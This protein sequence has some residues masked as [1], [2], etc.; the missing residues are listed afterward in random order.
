M[1]RKLFILLFSFALGIGL[2]IGDAL[3]ILA[4]EST[5]EEFTLEEITVTAQKRAENQQ[6]VGIPMAV[7]SGDALKELGRNDIDQILSQVSSAFI[8]RTSEGL[9]V[10]LR[11]VG[12]DTPAGYGDGAMNAPGTVSVN[13]NGVYTSKRPTGTG[14]Y[15]IERV[16]VLF[17]PQ[18]TMYA[19]NAP[20]GIVNVETA[21]PKLE[22]YE[23]GGTLEYA[24]Y[25]LLHTEGVINA[26]ISKSLAFRAAFN[27]TVRDG[28]VSNGGDDEDSKSARLRALWKPNDKFSFLITGEYQISSDRGMSGVPAFISQDDVKDPWYNPT[29]LT[30]SPTK[31]PQTKINGQIDY[32]F[33][34]ASMTIIPSKMNEDYDRTSSGLDR[35]GQPTTGST[36]G[37]GYEKGLETRFSSPGDSSIKWIVAVNMFKG[38]NYRSG[39]TD[40]ASGAHYQTDFHQLI[41]QTA[42]LGNITYP[43]TDQFRVVAGLRRSKDTA[44][45][46]RIEVIRGP[47]ARDTKSDM[48]YTG[49]DY[50]LGIEY[51]LSESSMMYAT[52]A[53]SYRVEGE[54]MNWAMEPYD[55]QK[56]ISYSI[57]SKNRFLGNKLQVNAA[58]FYYDYTNRIFQGMEMLFY[59]HFPPQP[60]ETPGEYGSVDPVTGATRS[61]QGPPDEGGRAPGKLRMYGLDLDNSIIITQN[62]KLNLSVSYLDSYVTNLVFDYEFL[63]DKDYSNR[64]PT[65]SPKWTIS[66]D[67]S[68]MFNLP[69]GGTLTARYDTR[70]Q[71]EYRVEWKDQS[72]GLNYRGFRDQEAHHMDNISLVYANPDGKWTFTGY[73]KN[74]WNYAEKRFM[75][76]MGQMTI[77]IGAPRTY[78][79]VLSVKF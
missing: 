22:T 6:K 12:F 50:K 7:F 32:D 31:S 39:T 68:H 48:K 34:F 25:N 72:M 18:S 63:T 37:W 20:G 28:Y 33:G 65:F 8:S 67:Y 57:G 47:G 24:N 35:S 4:Q 74:L 61:V 36:T 76:A 1:M 27:S 55:P 13:I 62:D 59:A 60:G 54:A 70:Y 11:G 26:P 71:T 41:K 45:S 14:L 51:D 43:V 64:I 23:A 19:S 56:N 49:T 66:L 10:T 3:F 21:K 52:Y 17:G 44:L 5:T 15:D 58:G 16:E 2:V 75:N 79:G 46:E 40:Y 38:E 53:T 73:T 78:G 42:F 69:N 29:A 9:R 77:N 30:G